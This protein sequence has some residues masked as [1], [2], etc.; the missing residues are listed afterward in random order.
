MR[1]SSSLF[2][3]G[4]LYGQSHGRLYRVVALVG[5]SSAAIATGAILGPPAATAAGSNAT[6]SSTPSSTTGSN[7]I[8]HVVVLLKDQH[9]DLPAAVSTI[10]ARVK[11]TDADQA[12]LVALAENNGGTAIRQL[13]VAN[14]FAV[15][16]SQ[17][18]AAALAAQPSVASVV[19][20]EEIADPAAQQAA[21][22]DSSSGTS[23]APKA[24]ALKSPPTSSTTCPTDPAKPLLEPEA[25]Q[26]THDAFAN[27]A[28]PSAQ[29]IATGKGVTVA[30]L[31]DGLDIDNPDFLRADG[32]HVFT[33]YRDFS[34]E[35]PHAPT[36]GG[37]AFGDASSIAAQGRQVYDL[38]TFVNPAHPLPPGCTIR[39]L[40]MAPGASLVGLKVFPIGGF[41]F[42]STILQALDWA[43]TH[44]HADVINESFGS[45]QYPDTNNDPT[46]VFN[47][48][49]V[50]AGIVVVA[51]TGDSSFENTIGSPASAPDVISVGATTQFRLYAQ[52]ESNGFQLGNGTYRSNAISSLSSA[53]F[54]QPGRTVDMVAPGDLGWSLCTPNTA[55]YLSCT[56]NN[57]N[58]ASLEEFGG[59]SEA[60]PLTA[61]AAA[62]VIQAY[63]DAHHGASPSAFLVKQIL[64]STADDLGLP[65]QEQGS[66]LLDALRAVRA[67][68]A[69]GTSHNTADLLVKPGQL[70]LTT[71]PGHD[72]RGSVAITNLSTHTQTVT[73]SVR[74][75]S[76]VLD[77]T[78]KTIAI[79]A[80][81]SPTFIDQLGRPRAYVN[82]TFTVSHNTTNLHASIAWPSAATI[83]RL[84]LLD[85]TGAYTAYS[86][87][88]GF[89]NFAEVAVPTPVSGTWTAILFTAT[90]AGGFTGDVK[91][92]ATSTANSS[93]G[94]VSPSTLTLKAGQT[95]SVNVSVPA[96]SPV[97]DDA[98]ALVLTPSGAST[99]QST[100][101]SSASPIGTTSV[102]PVV[103]RT[104]VSLRHGNA[105]FTGTFGGGNGR[106]G[107]PA[108]SET[109]EF[110]VPNNAPNLF[111]AVA[112]K[113]DPGQAVYAFLVDPNGEPVSEQ[114]NQRVDSSGN[115]VSFSRAIQ[116]D[117]V[118]PQ[119]G[120][121]QLVFAVLGPVAGASTTTPF[122]GLISLQPASVTTSG[123]PASKNIKLDAGKPVTATV[124]FTNTGVTDANVF[125]DGRLANRVDTPL[126]VAN[127]PYTFAQDILPP[128]PALSVPT[129]TNRLTV[130]STS[131]APT[132]FEISPFPADQLVNLSFEGDPDIEA[133]PP[134]THPSVTLSD[135]I[136]APQTWLA[137]PTGIGP[138]NDAGSPSVTNTFTAI[139]HTRPFDT[140][141]TS[142]SG[143]PL[144]ADVNSS[145]PAATPVTVGVGDHGT[146]T[147]TITP[148]GPS[149]TVVQGIL[150]LD[151][152]DAVTGSTNEAA[153]I[154]YSYT[155]S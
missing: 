65:A 108:P 89:G 97:G 136:I 138:F 2:S 130:S 152:W 20:D 86:L 48:Q 112:M 129:E 52:T 21:S 13:H 5:A 100:S 53:G 110:D 117:Q 34:G 77:Q 153:A 11:A 94:S 133:G 6:P 140:D 125:V 61:G 3:A 75:T 146:I 36:P 105:V 14:E 57:G 85:P 66:G 142:S 131:S 43:V 33:D 29:K 67:A 22:T 78:N 139:A 95:K 141:L 123:L 114:T 41:A 109:Y 60:A 10:A 27:P 87:P 145:A 127:N 46:A 18:G 134:G 25:L 55:L 30:F 74:N 106:A 118:N 32:S 56:D 49:L 40:G 70:D 124:S 84:V 38:S 119:A 47:E 73:A 9:D 8:E 28:T 17:A 96:S 92:S 150:Y 44:D 90:G 122:A 103:V 151:T 79:N 50:R 7:V 19:P 26:L 4:R 82:T 69:I 107:I 16:I 135:P 93:G 99:E 98:A 1:R 80:N 23:S 111:A 12:P 24:F 126:V 143:D 83:V 31:A 35:G 64:T 59:T 68:Q 42:N 58:P 102:V 148:S 120:R 101:S 147:V 81:T 132:L 63:R 54:T 116:L 144:L 115:V 15:T 71:S 121:W 155:V 88:Q 128:F 37:E 45:N 137:L 72:A 62:L 51:S 113:A 149:G 76:K 91:F 104:L 154:P 39:V